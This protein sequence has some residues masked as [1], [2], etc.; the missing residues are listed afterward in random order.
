LVRRE[1]LKSENQLSNQK[2]I[3]SFYTGFN[4]QKGEKFIK[5]DQLA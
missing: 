3:N 1:I 5:K 4:E 2:A